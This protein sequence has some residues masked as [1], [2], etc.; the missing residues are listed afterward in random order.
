MNY[1]ITFSEEAEEDISKAYQWYED[2]REGLGMEFIEAVRDAAKNVGYNPLFFSYRKENIRGYQ[3][4]RFPY[5]ILYFIEVDNVR[6]ISVFHMS[7]N[8][9]A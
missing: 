6:V 9:M 8:P 4:K 1:N 5:L 3:I 7:R 2:Q